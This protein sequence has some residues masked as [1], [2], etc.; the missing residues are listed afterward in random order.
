M[1]SLLAATA[2][3]FATV[4]SLSAFA[5]ETADWT[6][7]RG[8]HFNGVAEAEGLVDDWDAEGGDDSNLLWKR[9]DLGARSTPVVMNGRLYTITRADRGTPIEGEKVVCLDAKTGETLWENRFNVWMSDVPDTRVGWSSVVADPESGNVYVLGV[10]DLFLCINGKT[11]QTIWSKPLH[12]QFGLLSTYG[13]RTNF[14]VVHEDLV[15]ISGIIIN[16]GDAAKPN[17]RLIAMDKLTGEVVWFSG[18]RDLPYDTT[19]SA[20]TLTT[21]DG[22]R[23]LILGT[24]DGAIWGFQPRTGKPLW[25]Y[26]LSRRGIFATPLVDGNRVYCSHSE[27]NVS[28]SAMGAIAALELTGSGDDT[29]VKELWKLDELVV[30]RSAPVVVD[31]RL[32]VVDDR[33]KLWVIDADTGDMIAERITV[34]DRKQWPSLL[35]ADEKLY[36]LTENG[37]WAIAEITEDGVDFINKGRLRNEAFYASPILAGGKLYFQGTSALYC[38]GTEEGKQTPVSL[39]EQ[40]VGETPI[41]QNSEITQLLVTPAELLVEPGQSVE[42]SVR[43]FNELGQQL[44]S[45][46]GGDVTY[47]VSGPGRVENSTFIASEDA[48]HEAA[49]ITASV[50]NVKGSARVRIVPPLPWKFTFDDLSDPPVTWVGARYRHQIRPVDGSPALVKVSTIPKGARSRAWMGSSEL[51]NY[52]IAADVQGKRSN[53]QMPDIG[54]T[55]HGY[56]LDLMGNSQQ[57]QIRT[58]SP[59]LR[60]A[61]T[62]DFPWD[63]DR[64]YRMKLRAEVKGSGENAVAVLQGKVWPRDEAEPEAWTVT[65]EDKSPVMTASPGLYGNAKVAEIAIDNLE[66]TEN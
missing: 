11:G 6:F 32:Y 39:A 52:T 8:P 64:W 61:Q 14:P 22:Q 37:R 23:Q 28:G 12:E 17:H 15:I 3:V 48:S 24:G 66:V 43:V 21:I 33:C 45:P 31:G 49:V 4:T 55:A 13:G 20:P 50:G 7:W 16:W 62:V 57:L 63:P 53:G 9:D 25:H 38:V 2:F 42:L 56:V 5:D 30:G 65:A 1:G 47:A 41:E 54:L 36:I 44:A 46:D 59:Q 29:A 18:T 51:S 34:G 27:E 40:L 35:Y 26:D 19:Y 58:W 60:M 10:C